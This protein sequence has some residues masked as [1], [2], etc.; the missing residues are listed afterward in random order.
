M[1]GISETERVALATLDLHESTADIVGNAVWPGRKGRI[2]A[3]TGGG[4]YAAQMLLGRLRK[5]G[6]VSSRKPDAGATRWHLTRAGQDALVQVK[7]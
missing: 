5:R 3:V 1:G 2:C 7:P 4:D 6:L